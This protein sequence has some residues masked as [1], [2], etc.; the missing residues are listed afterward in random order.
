MRR[1]W[2]IKYLALLWTSSS[3]RAEKEGGEEESAP[4][5][6]RKEDIYQLGLASILQLSYLKCGRGVFGEI[7]ITRSH[8]RL[9]VGK[10]RVTER[11]GATYCVNRA[12]FIKKENIAGCTVSFA[13]FSE[14]FVG[15]GRGRGC[16]CLPVWETWKHHKQKKQ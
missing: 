8:R 14:G 4:E 6:R 16:Y 1:R 11:W 5:G 13:K 9:V 3:V 10:N 12:F 15:E 7:G 2:E